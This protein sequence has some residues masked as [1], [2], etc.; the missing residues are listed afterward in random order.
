MVSAWAEQA[1][2]VGAGSEGAD[3]ID[4]GT[5]GVNPG[6]NVGCPPVIGRPLDDVRSGPPTHVLPP[7]LGVN[8]MH[9]SGPTR[10]TGT[11]APPAGIV[12]T[13]V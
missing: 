8:T 2:R 9:P 6:M 10:Q 12:A 3:G 4:W 13:P 11:A 5:I 7:L 1:Y